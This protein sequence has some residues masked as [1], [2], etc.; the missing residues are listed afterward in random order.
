MRELHVIYTD[1]T[2][3]GA[4]WD[5]A[6]AQ[7][8]HLYAGRGSVTAAQQDTTAILAFAGFPE[9]SY[10]LHQHE[11]KHLIGDDGGEYLVRFTVTDDV[12][13]ADG[14]A[15]AEVVGRQLAIIENGSIKEQ[16]DRMPTTP[17]GEHIIVAVVPH[18]SLGWVLDQ[19]SPGEGTLACY[20]GG[21]DV[22]YSVPIFDGDRELGRGTPL[23]ELGLN[24]D[25]TIGEVC[26]KVISAEAA[27][28]S[29]HLG[30]LVSA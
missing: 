18:D 8:P 2:D 4:G 20:Y 5:I 12:N 16:L 15:R 23:S 14:E 9:G 27:G 10:N 30:S 3:E 6:C 26:D 21:E 1:L 29:V 25:S 11:Q 24:R 13:E 19:L 7:V 28:L 22:V 17:T